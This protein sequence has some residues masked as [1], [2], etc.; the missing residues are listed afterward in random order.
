VADDTGSTG[1]QEASRA[2]RAGAFLRRARRASVIPALAVLLGLLAGAVVIIVANALAG[3]GWNFLLPI[4]AYASMLAGALGSVDGVIRTL[5]EATPLIL[6]G[7]AVA[8][9]FKAGLFNIGANGQFLIGALAA[10]AVGWAVA[11]LSPI[12]AIPLALGGGMLFSAFYGFIPG[13]LKAWT[14]A[15]EVVTTI[16]L[17]FIAAATVAFLVT[18]PLEAP[19]FTFA[20]TGDVGNAA[21]PTIGDTAAHLGILIAFLAVPV[22]YWLLNRSVFGFEIRMVGANPSAARYAGIHAGRVVI[23]TMSLSAMLAGMAGAGQ[24]LG[25]THF[26]SASF[27]TSAGFDAIT[28]ALLGRV[29]PFGVLLASLLFGIMRAGS[30][31]MQIQVRVPVEIIDLIQAMILLFLT[32]DII[33]RWIFR[34]RAERAELA[35]LKTITRTYGQA[36]R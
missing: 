17:N 15:H 3:R 5:A 20:R 9:G 35:E 4:E 11:D 16:M 14:G 36:T 21:Y 22:I 29:H 28:I 32:A 25:L 33:V 23:L 19:G 12:L 34:I 31:L 1:A 2:S 18:G 26:V 13:A 27:S 30:G 6:A 10:A 8:V 7:L 24:V